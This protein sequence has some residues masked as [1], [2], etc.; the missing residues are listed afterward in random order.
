MSY[1]QIS[2]IPDSAARSRVGRIQLAPKIA[3]DTCEAFKDGREVE[4]DSLC[5]SRRRSQKRACRSFGGR[6][7]YCDSYPRREG[8]SESLYLSGIARGAIR[9]AFGKRKEKIITRGDEFH[10]SAGAYY[11]A[12]PTGF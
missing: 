10:S 3:N 1:R 2:K 7:I 11:R 8:G 4:D 12:V 6:W 5:R 9:A